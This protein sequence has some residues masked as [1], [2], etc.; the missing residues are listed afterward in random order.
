[1]AKSRIRIQFK[2]NLQP[3]AT[4]PIDTDEAQRLLQTMVSL[5]IG[6]P[7]TINLPGVAVNGKDVASAQLVDIE[8]R[9]RRPQRTGAR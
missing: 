5:N 1:M 3:V 6:K 9:P 4:E 2:G 8:V 7:V